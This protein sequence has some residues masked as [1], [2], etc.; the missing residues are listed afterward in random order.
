MIKPKELAPI[1]IS[2]I[3]LAFTISLLTSLNEYLIA[4]ATIFIVLIIN[5]L[6][7]KVAAYYLESEI[8]IKLW[9]VKRW[10]FRAHHYFKKPVPAGALMPIIITILS[11]GYLNWFA[12][13]VFD[14]K[15]KVYRAARRW[16]LYTFSE[17]TEWHTGLIA[18]WG[19]AANLIFAVIGYLLGYTD[20]A[21][22]NIFL[23]VFN[24]LPLADLDG[25]KIFFAD[26]VLWSFLCA[27]ALIF[28][29]YALFLV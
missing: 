4:L 27:I 28:L 15:K 8:E 7:K 24:L 19:I 11:Y 22:F 29:G 5:V 17:V 2:A 23:S 9:E 13:L 12:T 3:I 1:L 18:V 10:G 16:G 6:A 21:K 14:V 25:N 20:F 26:T